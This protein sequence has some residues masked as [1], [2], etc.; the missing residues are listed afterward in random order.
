MGMCTHVIRS[1]A[2]LLRGAGAPVENPLV[3]S[4]IGLPSGR[5]RLLF[6]KVQLGQMREN[7]FESRSIGPDTGKKCKDQERRVFWMPERT[8]GARRNARAHFFAPRSFFL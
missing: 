7:G 3:A 2:I 4:I 1:G 6:A 8:Q 5:R